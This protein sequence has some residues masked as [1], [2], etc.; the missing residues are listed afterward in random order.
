MSRYAIIITLCLLGYAF[1]AFL[2]EK[3][4]RGNMKNRRTK[5]SIRYAV[6]AVVVI[7]L[8]IFFMIRTS[9]KLDNEKP[10]ERRSTWAKETAT[11]GTTA[12]PIATS[13]KSEA[14]PQMTSVSPS[15]TPEATPKATPKMTYLVTPKASPSDRLRQVN[16][17]PTPVPP[18]PAPSV[19][20]KPA[21]R[22]P[23]SRP[24][25]S[26]AR[27]TPVQDYFKGAKTPP[28]PP[29]VMVKSPRFS[30]TPKGGLTIT[31]TL[32][33]THHKEKLTG[34]LFVL[35]Q[36]RKGDGHIHAWFPPL[37]AGQGQPTDFHKGDY[38][39]VQNY[40]VADAFIR[41]PTGTPTKV[42][43]YVLRDNGDLLLRKGFSLNL[44]GQPRPTPKKS[45]R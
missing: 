14:P 19:K 26:H 28:G 32:V 1:G 35:V 40:K 4:T 13:A 6:L 41:L 5:R 9:G 30:Y 20:N 16:V 7:F 44:P 21:K 18:T 39:S 37:S 36:A 23:S 12:T 27:P 34:R 33:N 10:A 11:T 2:I 42:V 3:S 22:S 31:Y 38:Y 45:T 15:A 43:F 25:E 8:G 29:L 17:T 24:T